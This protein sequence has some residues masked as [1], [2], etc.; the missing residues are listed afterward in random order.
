MIEEM[1]L[2]KREE[3]EGEERKI[4]ERKNEKLR[5]KE[6]TEEERK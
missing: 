3:R 5:R 1:Q 6:W 2:R 4:V